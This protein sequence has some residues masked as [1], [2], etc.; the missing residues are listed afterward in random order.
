MKTQLLIISVQVPIHK[1]PWYRVD[2]I[3]TC[4]K[5]KNLSNIERNKSVLKTR[6]STEAFLVAIFPY[7]QTFH[8]KP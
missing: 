1:H 3:Y 6:N 5:S 7:Q 8:V 2:V 4:Q